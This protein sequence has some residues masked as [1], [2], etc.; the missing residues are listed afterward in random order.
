[1]GIRRTIAA[2]VVVSVLSSTAEG[3]AQARERLKRH[4]LTLWII[5]AI[6]WLPLVWGIVEAWVS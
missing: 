6:L 2:A 4:N 3:R 1:M 5:A